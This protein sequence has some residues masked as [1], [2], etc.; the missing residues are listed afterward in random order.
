MQ[1]FQG[2]DSRK[3]PLFQFLG[4]FSNLPNRG[5]SSKKF[6]NIKKLEFNTV[7]KCLD[8]VLF[9][10]VWQG[11]WILNLASRHSQE[12]EFCTKILMDPSSGILVGFKKHCGYGGHDGHVG[13]IPC[14]LEKRED[15]YVYAIIDILNN[16][17]II[18]SPH[19]YNHNLHFFWIH[20]I[21]HSM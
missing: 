17:L 2:V 15:T 3:S 18:G 10:K 4:I 12:Y 9:L 11:F 13:S 7:L 6:L 5:D 16:V 21:H 19:T 1:M 20:S 14:Q 8:N